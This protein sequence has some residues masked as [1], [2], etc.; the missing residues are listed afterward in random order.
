MGKNVRSAETVA[1]SVSLYQIG[2]LLTLSIFKGLICNSSL[3]RSWERMLFVLRHS[4]TTHESHVL[5]YLNTAS[6]KLAVSLKHHLHNAGLVHGP[7][8]RALASLKFSSG[9]GDTRN[10]P[11]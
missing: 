3:I 10:S 11:I 2:P 4:L 5:N 8:L 1:S 6:R 9:N 7:K